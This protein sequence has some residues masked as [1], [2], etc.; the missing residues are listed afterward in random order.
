LDQVVW[1]E[2]CSL[3]QDQ[4]RLRQEYDRWLSVSPVNDN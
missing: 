1:E 3:L 2:V 4:Q